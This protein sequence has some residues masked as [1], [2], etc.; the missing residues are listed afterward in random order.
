MIT[1]G[2]LPTNLA[3][4]GCF[5]CPVHQIIAGDGSPAMVEQVQRKLDKRDGEVFKN[6]HAMELDGQALPFKDGTCS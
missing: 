1:L 3:L 5:S 2:L 4:A 6:V